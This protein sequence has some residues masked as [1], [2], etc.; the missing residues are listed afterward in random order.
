MKLITIRKSNIEPELSILRSKL[1]SE[2]IACFMKN[3]LTTQIMNFL[4]S[5][6]IELQI[7]D[8]DLDKAKEITS[9]MMDK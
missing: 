5:F 9:K 8:S 6:E 4:P 2:G 3:E 1:E 7:R